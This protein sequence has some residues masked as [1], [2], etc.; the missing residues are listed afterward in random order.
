MVLIIFL[1]SSNQFN[2]NKLSKKSFT[3]SFLVQPSGKSF[4]MSDGEGKQVTVEMQMPVR[5]SPS[6]AAFQH[7][8]TELGAS[9]VQYN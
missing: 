1:H 4:I 3:E 8:E 6:D 5:G 7:M 2:Y 9:G